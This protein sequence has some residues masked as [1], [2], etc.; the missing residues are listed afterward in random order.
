MASETDDPRTFQTWEDAFQYPVPVVRKLE[1]QL[2]S[3]GSENREKLRSLVGASYRDLLSTA[4][5]IIDMEDRM[6]TVET[7]VARI[8]RNCNTRNIDRIASNAAK[9]QQHS[10]T[11]DAVRYTFASQIAVLRS[12]PV[13]IARL[14][15]KG[16]GLLVPAKVL[17]IGRL[18]HKALSQSSR[19]A[20]IIDKLRDRLG[21]LRGKLLRR[22]DDRLL[23][24]SETGHA[25][26]T[27]GIN[28][29]VE[30]LCAYSLATTSA[31]TFVLRHFL[32]ARKEEIIRSVRQVEGLKENAVSALKLCVQTCLDTQSV[33][34]RR[35]ADSLLK[36]KSQHLVQDPD[37]RALYELNLD[38]HDKWIGQEARNYTPQPRHDELQRT[39]AEKLLQS[40]SKDVI[41]AFLKEIRATLESVNDLNEVAELRQ[42]LIETWIGSGSRMVGVKSRNVLD[43]LRDILNTRLE[44][45]MRIRAQALKAVVDRISSAL[46]APTSLKDASDESLWTTTLPDLSDGA[47]VFK[48]SVV[49]TYHGRDRAVLEIVGAYEKWVDSFLE[50]KAIIKSMKEAR[51]DDPFT[52]EVD[53]E[54]SD[55]D[56]DNT[57]QV[58]LSADDPQLLEETSRDSLQQALK[59]LGKEFSK[60]AVQST[61]NQEKLDL[62]KVTFLL[63]V[64]REI[65]DRVPGLRLNERS[66]DLDMPFGEDTLKPL[67]S[68]LAQHIIKSP[69]KTY[70]QAVLGIANRKSKSDILWEGAPSLPAQPSPAAFRFLQQL[71]RTMGGFGSDLWAPHC[72]HI[73]K[74]AAH[75]NIVETWRECGKQEENQSDE[76]NGREDGNLEKQN[77]T[78]DPPEDSKDPPRSSEKPNS[79]EI[80]LVKQKQLIFDILFVECFLVTSGPSDNTRFSL[81][82]LCKAAEVDESGRKRLKEK[83]LEYHKKTYLLFALLA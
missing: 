13:V 31:P 23:S 52:E 57:K 29:L 61:E 19:K 77:G 71:V 26:S 48:T 11:Q 4:E 75:Q 32:D 68:A 34:P 63:R 41:A 30:T 76:A 37:V 56:F 20:E 25:S 73:L 55:D 70:H 69:L 40:W 1:Q 22:I 78:A 3:N 28:S 12:C 64:I 83:A 15:E 18:L 9:L 10:R 14:L 81:E 24:K 47:R 42:E 45:I 58:L 44:S 49:N 66:T 43:D 5:M 6:S 74:S 39:D 38:I 50:V 36:L 80:R 54:D 65:C 60:F 35:L 82:D 79:N 17:V 8:S 27:D 59:V 2:R 21:S 33:F 53:L 62:G 7:Q 51:W 67:H 72:V 46:S 16:E